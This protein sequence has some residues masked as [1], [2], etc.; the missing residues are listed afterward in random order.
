MTIA[1]DGPASMSIPGVFQPVE[2][3]S[4]LL[5]DGGVVNNFPVDVA[6]KL[7]ADIIIGSDVSGG[8]QPK[9]KLSSIPSLLFQTGMLKSNLKNP[10]SREACDILVD[11]MPHLT[12]S[13]GDFEKAGAIHKEGKKAVRESLPELV[14]LSKQLSGYKQR[15]H[16]LPEVEDAFALDSIIFKDIDERNLDLVKAR[17]AIEPGETYS[18]KEMIDGIDRVMGTNLFNQITYEAFFKDSLLV[19]DHAQAERHDIRHVC[20]GH[21]LVKNM[22]LHQAPAGAAMFNRPVW[23]GPTLFV[24]HLLEANLVFAFKLYALVLLVAD[25]LRNVVGEECADFFSKGDFFGRVGNV[26]IGF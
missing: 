5:V 2:Y 21:F 23:R 17:M 4:T 24:E 9:E 3:D 14:A 8:M 6:K 15:A 26:H 13:T 25:V 22:L 7:G 11:H 16:A 19:A 10:E 18:S 20:V 12:H 1:S